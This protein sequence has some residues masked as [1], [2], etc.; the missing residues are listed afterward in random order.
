[1]EKCRFCNADLE[2]NN[3]LCPSCGKDNA[4]EQTPEEVMTAPKTEDIPPEADAAEPEA[5]AAGEEAAEK[6]PSD[7]A[8][9]SREIKKGIL[10]SPGMIAA[11]AGVFVVLI[12]IVVALVVS[13]MKQKPSAEPAV[14]EPAQETTEATNPTVP[15]DGNPD[16]VTCK[17]SY[18]VTDDEA[19]AAAD[20]VVATSGDRKLTNRDLQI[21]YWLGVQNFYAQY[22]SYA[23]YFGLDHT[24]SMDTQVCGV[25][26][27]RTW[28]QYFLEEALNSWQ[29][30]QAVAAEAE[31][32]GFRM[33]DAEQQELDTMEEGLDETAKENGFEDAAHMIRHNFGPAATVEAYRDFWKVYFLG[34]AYYNQM[35]ETS[36]PTTEEV[37]AFF[38]EHEAEYAEN[39]LTKD[40]R[41]VDVRHILV[42]PE[43]ATSD[44][45]RTE[46]FPEEA[47]QAGEANAKAI[48]DTWLA[49]EK[50]E[51][52]FAALAGEKT[53]DPGSKENGGLYSGVTQGQMVEAFDAWCF[54]DSRKPGDYGIVKTEYG[55]HVMFFSGSNTL[56]E[57]QARNDLISE[58][59][60]AFV[61]ES[62]EKHPM[63][64]DYS[65]ICLGYVDMSN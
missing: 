9:P 32:V 40:T 51:E 1:M 7:A 56:W 31:A 28:Q 8:E 61:Q 13:G 18:T 59:M 6:E 65:A 38:A 5:P 64:V 17:G 21:Q 63:T 15:A 30:Y 35:V 37:A 42:Y 48:L 33:P 29:V 47:W 12:A 19:L 4:P 45:V 41:T 20:T 22:G 2:E 58:K 53:Q 60:E 25:A 3:S 36:T 52:S 16:D 27:N 57:S 43:G 23:S 14:T 10:V 55:Y 62:M 54:D 39:G 26:E 34:S 46:T 49:G 24:Q 44:T 50:T 11:A